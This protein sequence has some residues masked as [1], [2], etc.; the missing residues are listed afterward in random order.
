MINIHTFEQHLNIVSRKELGDSWKFLPPRS[1][2]GT[3]NIDFD[4]GR[5]VIYFLEDNRIHIKV[6]RGEYLNRFNIVLP[7][8]R[9]L[10]EYR[11]FMISKPTFDEF[12]QMEFNK[13]EDDLTKKEYNEATYKYY[14]GDANDDD[15]ISS[16]SVFLPYNTKDINAAAM[17]DATIYLR[18]L[19]ETLPVMLKGNI[20]KDS[21]LDEIDGVKKFI[22]M[23]N[24]Q[25][26][27]DNIEEINTVNF[28]LYKD[29]KFFYEMKENYDGDMGKLFL[30][31]LKI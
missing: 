7:P 19:N 13:S 30:E 28:R 16:F 9:D 17:Y 26:T 2:K 6:T 22:N 1:K 20:L 18:L 25:I 10:I 15:E 23:K 11:V 31:W 24:I 5:R 14:H 8:E 21:L 12:I 27:N 3:K 4:L 29:S